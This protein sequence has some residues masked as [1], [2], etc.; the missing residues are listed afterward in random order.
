M[1]IRESTFSR[2]SL[3]VTLTFRIF[4]SGR[5][6]A[7]EMDPDPEQSI[8]AAVLQ[9]GG[10]IRYTGRVFSRAER[11][12]GLATRNGRIFM[13]PIVFG[14]FFN[15]A[16]PLQF[17]KRPFI[18]VY[19]PNRNTYGP[20]RLRHYRL[21]AQKNNDPNP[22]ARYSVSI[23]VPM[24][25]YPPTRR[26]Q[27]FDFDGYPAPGLPDGVNPMDYW[28]RFHFPGGRRPGMEKDFQVLRIRNRV[29]EVR[30]EPRTVHDDVG[31]WEVYRTGSIIPYR[32][33]DLPLGVPIPEKVKNEDEEWGYWFTNP[34]YPPATE[35]SKNSI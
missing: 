28:F 26:V 29:R 12:N 5:I 1:S 31:G 8:P 24:D 15:R 2:I 21:N 22:D 10:Q 34:N 17:G 20:L 7:V 27:G 30:T 32:R 23:N 35:Y 13:V 3:D 9:N 4:S 18:H 33:D 14:T 16:G 19:I 6:L 25:I 11:F